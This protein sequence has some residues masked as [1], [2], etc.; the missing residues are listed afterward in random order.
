MPAI[1]TESEYVTIPATVFNNSGAN[2]YLSAWIDFNNDGTFNNTVVSSGGERLVAAITV[3]SNA[4]TQTINVTFTV[5]PDASPGGESRRALPPQQRLAT[6]PPGPAPPGRSRTIR[7]AS[8]R[9]HHRVPGCP[10]RPDGRRLQPDLHHHR[11]HRT[12]HLRASAGSLPAGL[13]FN[14]SWPPSGGHP[15][16]PPPLLRS[17]STPPTPPAA[18][19]EGLYPLPESSREL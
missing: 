18:C 1:I 9:G 8:A 4:S 16:T 6:L 10:F 2:A 12:G 5:P 15:T 19:I 3:P 11:R 7:S 13:T 14:T 17:P